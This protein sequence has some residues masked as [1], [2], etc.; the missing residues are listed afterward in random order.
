MKMTKKSLSG[1]TFDALTACELSGLTATMLDYLTREKF[2][3]PSG[4]SKRG[5]GNKRLFT[6]GDIVALRVISQLL[7][8]GLEIRRLSR[9][10]KRF[11]K[12]VAASQPGAM[13]FRFIVT[14]GVDVFFEADG[15][16]ESLTQNGQLAF[17][18]LIDLTHCDRAIREKAKS[19]PVR[20][21]A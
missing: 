4:S 18:F 10:L 17:M 12:L 11:R 3:V 13:P 8:S 20:L 14:D 21:V 6:F 7:S 5:R 9:G 1:L 2:I 15:S 16:L 19:L